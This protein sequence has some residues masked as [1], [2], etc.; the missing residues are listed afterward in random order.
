MKEEF[1]AVFNGIRARRVAAKYSHRERVRVAQEQA[2]LAR[3]VKRFAP[4]TVAKRSHE[5]TVRALM[6]AAK[7][8]MRHKGRRY[9]PSGIAELR[10]QASEEACKLVGGKTIKLGTLRA[11]KRRRTFA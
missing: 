7:I 3:H 1:Q 8:A 2:R 10:Q 11:V 4:E 5:R 6:K 9:T